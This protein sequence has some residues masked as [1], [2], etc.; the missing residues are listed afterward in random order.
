MTSV[1][2]RL[3]YYS[4]Y[5]AETLDLIFMEEALLNLINGVPVAVA[6]MYVW[7]VSEKNHRQ[8]IASWRDTIEK[9]DQSMKEM[10]ASITNLVTEIQKLTFIIET[11]VI[12]TRKSTPRSK[13]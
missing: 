6:V 2:K 7:I 10:Q 8:E 12:R 11:Y 4:R 13:N 1:R 9:K 3:P 5:F